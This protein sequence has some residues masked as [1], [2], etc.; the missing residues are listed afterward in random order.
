MPGCCRSAHQT[1]AKRRC[2]SRFSPSWYQTHA[3]ENRGSGF[4]CTVQAFR[5]APTDGTRW[6]FM[7]YAVCLAVL[8]VIQHA[9]ASTAVRTRPQSVFHDPSSLGNSRSFVSSQPP[10][11]AHGGPSWNTQRGPLQAAPMTLQVP[12]GAAACECKLSRHPPQPTAG[13]CCASAAKR[14]CSWAIS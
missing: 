14:D 6:P 5:Y 8:Q 4:A 2:G 11:T 13:V 9:Q 3:V 7:E 1:V 10:R 12:C